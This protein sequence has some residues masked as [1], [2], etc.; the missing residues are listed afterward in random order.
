M[1]LSHCY[2]FMQT[3][4]TT[5][6]LQFPK[7]KENKDVHEHAFGYRNAN[8]KC[9]DFTV[10]GPGRKEGTSVGSGKLQNINGQQ[11]FPAVTPYEAFS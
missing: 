8:L 7:A 6:Y 3:V 4:K 10:N 9:A 5:L 11:T 1:D 2:I